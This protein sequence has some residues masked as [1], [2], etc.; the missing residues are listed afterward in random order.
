MGTDEETTILNEPGIGH[1]TEAAESD[2]GRKDTVPDLR[3]DARE[4]LEVDVHVQAL[5]EHV[6]YRRC[7]SGMPDAMGIHGVPIVR[8]L[9]TALGLVSQRVERAASRAIASALRARR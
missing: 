8:V 3:V 7:V 1:G 9:V 2:G 6:R 4:R 5:V